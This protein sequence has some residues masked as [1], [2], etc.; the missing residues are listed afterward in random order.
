M[1]KSKVRKKKSSSGK[2]TGLWANPGSRG[3][4][5]TPVLPPGAPGG[6][7]QRMG[8]AVAPESLLISAYATHWQHYMHGQPANLCMSAVMTLQKALERIGIVSEPVPVIAEVDFMDGRPP[9]LLGEASPQMRG[10][11]WS[12]HLVLWLPALGR[13]VDPTIYQVNRVKRGRPIHNGI[14]MN[15]GTLP[16]EPVCVEKEGNLVS[17]TLVEGPAGQTW[18]QAA[19]TPSMQRFAETASSTLHAALRQWSATDEGR[20]IV[21]GASDPDI[22]AGLVRAGFREA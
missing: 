8:V 9:L 4:A 6:S 11:Q 2:K 22:V 16:N 1:P 14:I 3:N 21:G 19:K 20:A 12:G 13:L 7:A 18:Q 17:Y 10:S 15:L 5:A